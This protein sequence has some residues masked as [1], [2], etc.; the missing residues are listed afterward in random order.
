MGDQRTWRDMMSHEPRDVVEDDF[1][2]KNDRWYE[3][4]FDLLMER[5]PGEWIAIVDG[6]I[7]ATGTT[8]SDVER[9]AEE[10]APDTRC[11]LYFMTRTLF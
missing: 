6:K 10:V 8:K 11:S 2:L 4:N 1:E 7:I 9:N 5:Y 3:E